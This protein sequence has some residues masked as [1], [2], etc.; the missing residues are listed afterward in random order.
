L[1]LPALELP[2]AVVEQ[3]RAIAGRRLRGGVPSDSKGGEHQ[4]A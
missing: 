1:D 4:S 3:R 2:E